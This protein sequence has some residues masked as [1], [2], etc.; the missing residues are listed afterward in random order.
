MASTFP[1]FQPRL[2]VSYNLLNVKKI[3]PVLASIFILQ[4]VNAQVNLPH[5][6]VFQNND[7]NWSDGIAEDGDGGSGNIN[8]LNIQIYAAGETFSL[9]PG[10]TM[11]WHDNNYFFSNDPAYHGITPG[12][13]IDV[14]TN[15][16]PAMVMRSDNPANNFSLQSIR[17]YD[18]GG[19]TPH[20]IAAYDN[21]ALVGSIE[22]AFDIIDYA[23][24]TI[25]QN[26]ELTPAFFG[27]IDEIRF[28]PKS[29]NTVFYLSL[30][31]ISLAA[32]SSTLPVK[33]EYFTGRK[34]HNNQPF[35]L[36]WATSSEEKTA[37]SKSKKAVT[38][39][40]SLPLAGCHRKA[41]PG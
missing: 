5:T 21:G 41:I 7:A 27:N 28:Y 30:N 37:I 20:I 31:N 29:P 22:V 1:G 34:G 19:T 35:Y 15:G 13:D 11:R 25:S 3:Y 16:V 12:P 17:L 10:S 14:T 6:L 9:F 26:D 39:P 32:P 4:F 40:I 36:E 33:L 38:E 2:I 18:W 23:P 8:G 24:K